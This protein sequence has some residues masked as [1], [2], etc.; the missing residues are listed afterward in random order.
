MMSNIYRIPFIT[1]NI[2]N[3]KRENHNPCQDIPFSQ[4]PQQGE[5]FITAM[6]TV[7]L[8]SMSIRRAARAS[9]F[10]QFC[11]GK[12]P[13]D[14]TGNRASPALRRYHLKSSLYRRRRKYHN[15]TQN[16]IVYTP[17][18]LLS[19]MDAGPRFGIALNR[20][21]TR[22]VHTAAA[23]ATCPNLDL[24]RLSHNFPDPSLWYVLT[25]ITLTAVGRQHF[26]G[27]LWGHLVGAVPAQDEP[28]QG[29]DL[30]PAP[31]PQDSPKLS[32]EMEQEVAHLE[33]IAMRLREGL[34]KMS[35]LFGYPRVRPPN[36]S[37][38]TPT[39]SQNLLAQCPR[40]KRLS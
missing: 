12:D 7:G 31:I 11:A 38:H 10:T 18:G 9:S 22:G 28:R 3:L 2:P 4:G 23:A 39:T 13:G 1:Y 24:A 5:H 20:Q 15:L 35:V 14:L 36:P 33:L 26:I 16:P 19:V 40:V 6:L 37:A 8:C 27:Q 29:G 30:Q 25:A 34:M 17:T 21:S 32:P